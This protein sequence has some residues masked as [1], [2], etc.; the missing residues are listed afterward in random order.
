[1]NI[2]KAAA[3]KVARATWT[4][5]AAASI[6]M[7]GSAAQAA[8]SGESADQK[9]VGYADLNLTDVKGVQVL[10]W[11]LDSAAKTVCNMPDRRELARAA[12]ARQCVDQAMVQAIATVNNP[13]LTSLYLAKTG[14]MDRRVATVARIG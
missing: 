6:F 12:N 11:R 7:L 9:T 5:L 8:D 3:A 1:L 2:T 13:L 10:Y 4:T 14:T